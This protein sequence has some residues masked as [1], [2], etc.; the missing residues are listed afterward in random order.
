M[1]YLRIAALVAAAGLAGA[2]P[3]IA[4]DAPDVAGFMRTGE[5]KLCLSNR[6]IDSTKILNKQQILFKMKGGDTYLNETE[7]CPGLSRHS[8]LSYE[9]YGGQVCNTTIVTLLEPA[10]TGLQPRGSCLLSKFEKLERKT[11]SAD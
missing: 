2:A 8:A 9:V 3:A 7:G 11:A 10:G 5:T 6:Q 4:G 1:T